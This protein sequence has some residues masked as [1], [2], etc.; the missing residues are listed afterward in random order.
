MIKHWFDHNPFF[1]GKNLPKLPGI[2]LAQQTWQKGLTT[3][4]HPESNTLHDYRP[5][6]SLLS[7]NP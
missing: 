7:E 2:F 3:H 6:I 5:W 1:G 4:L